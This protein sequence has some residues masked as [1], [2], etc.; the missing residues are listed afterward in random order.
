MVNLKATKNKRNKKAL[1]NEVW[2]M[3]ENPTYYEVVDSDKYEG[4][5]Y[6]LSDLIETDKL[7]EFG[8]DVI[9]YCD[10]DEMSTKAY[11]VV[12][13]CVETYLGGQDEEF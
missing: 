2:K 10:T 13:N 9:K 1:V 4:V 8:Y 11:D 7:E 6:I 12:M 5:S 3:L